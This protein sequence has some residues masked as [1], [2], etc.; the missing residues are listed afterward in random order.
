SNE[1]DVQELVGYYYRSTKVKPK[2]NQYCRDIRTDGRAYPVACIPNMGKELLGEN[3]KDMFSRRPFMAEFIS[4][5]FSFILLASHVI[6]TSP[7]EEDKMKYILRK[8]FDVDHYEELGVGIN[9]A[10]YARFAEVKVTLDF[11]REIRAR[12]NQKDIIF[13]GD[14]NLEYDNQ[15]WEHVLPAFPGGKLYVTD[16]TTVSERR[17]NADGSETNGVANDYD[18]FILDEEETSECKNEKGVVDA[19]AYDFYEGRIAGYI[20]RAYRIRKDRQYGGK[21]VVDRK[22][23]KRAERLYILPYKNGEASFKTIGIKKIKVGEKTLRV[24]GITEDG[25]KTQKYIEGFYDRVLDSQLE[26]DSY[27]RYFSETISDHKPIYMS[28][29]N[30]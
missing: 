11:M 4:G 27:Y 28:C 7:R 10:N 20:K 23:Y 1:T 6:Y 12:F 30:N 18:H 29:S 19:K 14:M 9:A 24:R 3:K 2:V 17:Y 22:K 25:A 8:S 16:K 26:D 13:V 5:R 21:Y 15:F